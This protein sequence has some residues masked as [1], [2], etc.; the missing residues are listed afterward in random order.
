MLRGGQASFYH[1]VDLHTIDDHLPTKRRLAALDTMLKSDEDQRVD[2]ADFRG[3]IYDTDMHGTT[4]NLLQQKMDQNPQ[5][6]A[7]FR[8]AIEDFIRNYDQ[9]NFALSTAASRS[10]K[11]L[12]HGPPGTGKTSTMVA[13]C[14]AHASAGNRVLFTSGQNDLVEDAARKFNTWVE[15]TFENGIEPHEYVLFTGAYLKIATSP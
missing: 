1:A 5:S 8:A 2:G 12:L 6:S 15:T 10:G 7:K 3:M 9:R 14:G 11:S 13:S 4:T